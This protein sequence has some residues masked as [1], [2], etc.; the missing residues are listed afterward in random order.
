MRLPLLTRPVRL[1]VLMSRALVLLRALESDMPVRGGC[2]SLSTAAGAPHASGGLPEAKPLGTALD[3]SP[4]LLSVISYNILAPIY[5]R[6][7]DRRTGNVQA[8]A[9]FPWAEPATERLSWE[10]RRPR[11]QNQ[12]AR[13]GADLICLQ[14]VQFDADADGNFALPTWLQ[15]AGYEWL[16]PPQ[17]DLAEI[18]KRNERVLGS[19]CAVG[20]AL[21]Y[22]RGRLAPVALPRGARTTGD[23]ASSAGSLTRV[24]ALLRGV[25]GGG[26][27]SSAKLAVMS[28]HFDAKSE[29]LRV[30]QLLKCVESAKATTPPLHP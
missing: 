29:E 21:L 14:E 8:F 26:L 25:P 1:P 15:L 22:R 5:V 27:S 13:C 28:V 19:A 3:V 12:L 20:N 16:V 9:A 4:E 23:A 7:L 10:A 6:P 30:K 17:R 18:S 2:A 24:A 11:L